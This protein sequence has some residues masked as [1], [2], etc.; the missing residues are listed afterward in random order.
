M[1]RSPAIALVLLLAACAGGTRQAFVVQDANANQQFL[2]ALRQVRA[3]E[4]GCTF[5]LQRSPN[6]PDVSRVNVLHTPTGGGPGIVYAVNFAADCKPDRGGWY[7]ERDA[8]G[9]AIA[10]QLC[11]RSCQAVVDGG[12]RVDIA[13]GCASIPPPP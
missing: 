8:T 4:V 6:P 3:A 13:L 11:P 2:D 5:L 12:G 10:I 7:F 1:R 9:N